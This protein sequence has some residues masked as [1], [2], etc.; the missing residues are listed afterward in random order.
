MSREQAIRRVERYFD[1]GGFVADLARRVAIRTESQDPERKGELARYLAAEMQPSLERLGFRCRLLENPKP[2]GGP[3]LLAERIEDPKLATVFS[4]GHGDVIRGQDAQWRAGLDPWKVTREG[5]R[6]YG[7]GTADN[8]ASTRSISR[9][10]R[11]CSR[12]A[13]G[14]ASTSRC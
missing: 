12:R 14:S 7:R 10:S 6:L 4:Y 9:R 2:N 3:F 11:R 1:E 5:E 13:A 8:R